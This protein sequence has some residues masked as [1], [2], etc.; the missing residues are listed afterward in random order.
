MNYKSFFKHIFV[1]KEVSAKNLYLSIEYQC[2][3]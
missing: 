3:N 1:N 2:D